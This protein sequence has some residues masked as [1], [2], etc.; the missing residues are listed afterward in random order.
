MQ[1]VMY[2]ITKILKLESQLKCK[3]FDQSLLFVFKIL[4]FLQLDVISVVFFINLG[5]I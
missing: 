2:F 5:V 3:G 1:N 4:D